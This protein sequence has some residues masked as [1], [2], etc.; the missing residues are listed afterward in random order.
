MLK[1]F[2]NKNTWKLKVAQYFENVELSPKRS[3]E[4]EALLRS[5][6]LSLPNPIGQPRLWLAPLKRIHNSGIGYATAA[7]AAAAFTFAVMEIDKESKDPIEELANV[8]TKPYPPDFDLDGDATSFQSI[9]QELMPDESFTVEIPQHIQAKFAP[10][11]GRFFTWA[12]ESGVRIRLVNNKNGNTNNALYIV[13]L[14]KN[15]LKQFPK[16]KVERNLASAS[17]NKKKVKAWRDGKY[18]FALVQYVA[19]NEANPSEE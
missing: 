18:G 6:P 9:V 1:T 3:R 2:H 16:E 4:L 19:T 11:D 12:G 13:R 15:A 5:T 17:G 7:I 8:A 14:P 10:S